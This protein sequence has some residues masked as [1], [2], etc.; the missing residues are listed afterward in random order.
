MATEHVTHSETMIMGKVLSQ[1][2]LN[3]SFIPPVLSSFPDSFFFS[4]SF[5]ISFTC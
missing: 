2:L 5:S 3:D 1:R 4:F